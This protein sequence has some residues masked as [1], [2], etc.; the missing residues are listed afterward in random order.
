MIVRELQRSAARSVATIVKNAILKAI[1]L[2][3][4]R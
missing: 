4:R 3:G 2:G 1:G